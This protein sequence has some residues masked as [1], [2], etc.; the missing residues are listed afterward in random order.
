MPSFMNTTAPTAWG[1]FDSDAA[2]QTAADGMITFVKRSLGEEIVS[3]ELTNK[4]IWTCFEEATLEYGYYINMLNIKSQLANMMGQATGSIDLTNKNPKRTLE[5]FLQQAD[6]YTPVVGVG[7]GGFDSTLGYFDIESGRQDYNLY[8][9]LKTA[10]SSSQ[11]PSGTLVVDTVPSGSRGR[12]KILEIM[13]YEPLAAQNFL[14]NASNITNFLATNFNYES[15]VN[16]T[17]FYVLP[18][19]EDVLRRGMLEEAFRVRRSQYSYQVIGSNIRFFPI[20]QLGS[21]Y[22]NIGRIYIRVM[23]GTQNALTSSFVDD[24]INGVSSPS[25]IP[26]KTAISY[27][28]INEP[29]RQWIRQ[30][31][32]A[33]CKIALGHVRSKIKTIPIP[34]ADVTLDG[35]ELLQEGR[36]D[37]EKLKT[38]L[39]EQLAE[40]SLDK[41]AEREATLA[42]QLNK[43]LKYIPM[44]MGRAITIGLS[45]GE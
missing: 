11:F 35:P 13:H 24:S 7:T 8:T 2:F 34:G 9:E 33:L 22:R 10:Y 18:V 26:Y 42:E 3:V 36:D 19:F 15:Y 17:V 32:L 41:L 1:Y 14:L 38:E 27:T 6:A 4:M 21:F 44:V 25:N 29:G 43:Q 28:S 31:T 39:K 37:L 30:A 12:F 20:P 45:N 23:A 5:F 16:S 40:L